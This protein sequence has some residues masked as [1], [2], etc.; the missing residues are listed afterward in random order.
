MRHG[1]FLLAGLAL[2][3]PAAALGAPGQAAPFCV[4]EASIET[5]RAA[6]DA[7][8]TTSAALVEAYAA[9][10]AA[11]D[12]A[13]PR[14]NA[15]RALNPDAGA[16]AQA[17]DAARAA[18][19][20]ILS[21]LDGIP[22]LI[23][24]NIST[25]DR[26]LT[27][28]GSVALADAAAKRDAFV[29]KQLRASGA[30]ILGKANLTEFANFMAIDM[31]SGYS[32]LA[33]QVLDP[34]APSTEADGTPLVDP[35]GSSSGSAVAA[36]ASLAAAAIGTETSGSLLNPASN[37]GL[38]TVKPSIG[39]ISRAGIVPIA[40]SQDTAGPLTRSVRD[41]AL[42]LGV[43]AGAD[44]DDPT[45]LAGGTRD[46]VDYA[47]FLQADALKG[48]RIGVPRDPADK[49]NDV[50]YGPL[51]QG[52]AAIMAQ[53]IAVLKAEG[54]TLVEASIPTAGLVDA[55]KDSSIDV[56]VTNPSSDSK[57]KTEPIPSVLIYEFK[58]DLNHYLSS[59]LPD[60]KV[61]TL[62]DIIAFNQENGPAALKFGQD[63]LVAA[64]ATKGDL[65]EP[66]YAA[67]RAL[68]LKTARTDGI[69]AY[70]DQHQLDAILFPAYYGADIA[71]RAGYPSVSVPAGFL[72]KI[73]DRTVPDFPFNVTF[74]AK[75]F[76]EGKLLGFAYA[77]EQATKTRRAPKLAAS[78]QDGEH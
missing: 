65:S 16:I 46:K 76:S 48:A 6:L 11:L 55:G 41:A 2:S 68:D 34:Y 61:K 64:E 12:H 49:P 62:A 59:Y 67:A 32:S 7:G 21:P 70:L 4:D 1:L 24:D 60:A 29:V 42:L 9:R 51:D 15:V 57:G 14:L 45:T 71:A 33:G 54:A 77:F 63:I 58:H 44:P 10:I 26:Q 20:K 18:G 69:D 31:P 25:A 74:T 35:G 50:Y 37:N 66:A 19:A 75:A 5:L 17:R 38:V 22:I 39:L 36:A 43:L 52:Q 56:A 40:A 3:A 72:S 8:K 73:K 78:C 27:T 30:V 23:K 47:S 53:A 13:G 28:A